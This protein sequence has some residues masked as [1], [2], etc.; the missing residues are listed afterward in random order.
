MNKIL[1]HH[2]DEFLE[3]SEG[4]LANGKNGY[5]LILLEYDE[6]VSLVEWSLIQSVMDSDIKGTIH[7]LV[8]EYL[9]GGEC[10]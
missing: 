7:G 9:Y 1:E 8:A 2:I 6:L 3:T 4:V 10:E 5:G